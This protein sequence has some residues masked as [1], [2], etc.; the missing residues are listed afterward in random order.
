MGYGLGVDLG[1]SFTGVAISCHG[2]TRIVPLGDDPISGS[3]LVTVRPPGSLLVREIDNT[4]PVVLG[5]RPY[6]PVAVLAEVL[7]SVLASV[8]MSEGEVPEQVVLTCP[9]V[10][11]PAR[12][13]QFGEVSRRV[14]LTSVTVVSEPEAAVTSLVDGRKL[15]EDDVVVVYD[16]GGVTVDM[17][18]VRVTDSGT[19][20]LGLPEGADGAGGADFD[21]LLLAHVDRVLGG[22]LSELDLSDPVAVG[23]LTGVRAEC[24]RAK[25][26]L[27]RTGKVSVR[28][29]G[30]AEM[31]GRIEEVQPIRLTRT[32]FEA[33]IREPLTSTLAGLSR[34]LDSAGV[35]ASELRAVVLVGGSSRIPLVSRLLND[36]VGRPVLTDEHPQYCVALGAAAIADGT[37]TIADGV[38]KITPGAPPIT[39]SIPSF[40]AATKM[41]AAVK[42]V[43]N[44][45]ATKAAE[46]TSSGNKQSSGS[47]QRPQGK[48][49]FGSMQA[50]A[51]KQGKNKS[52]GKPASESDEAAVN[53]VVA[54]FVAP[55]GTTPVPLVS[56]RPLPAPVSTSRSEAMLA[57]PGG[58]PFPGGSA[59]SGGSAFPGGIALPGDLPLSAASG[60]T[61]DVTAQPLPRRDG[62]HRM[63]RM[64]ERRWWAGG[65]WRTVPGRRWRVIAA[66][67]V[68]AL[69]IGGTYVFTTVGTDPDPTNSV[70]GPADGTTSTPTVVPSSPQTEP[71]SVPAP[72]EAAAKTTPPQ[73]ETRKPTQSAPFRSAPDTVTASRSGRIVGLAGRCLDVADGRAKNGTAVQIFECNSSPA[74]KW[75]VYK[76]G[77][78]RA[79]NKCLQAV[80]VGA[81][82]PRLQINTCNGRAS[83]QW[84][85][86]SGVIVNPASAGCLDVQGSN[87]TART[88]VITANCGPRP[89]QTWWLQ[90]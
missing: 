51:V 8:T 61:V 48:S 72:T 24:V 84:V 31:I 40:A 60:P 1:T 7:R 88:P 14:G 32:E 11:G 52:T 33:L 36:S 64:R 50:F 57:F 85:V 76:D 78:L 56:P 79:M 70:A 46:D 82:R 44:K 20:I 27:S 53:A 23:V 21:D 26:A 74:Q 30:L 58:S 86:S 29:I 10:W 63:P 19:E 38:R 15:V 77:T 80:D 67:A 75:S 42:S 9:A 87:T 71:T 89:G 17:T 65:G 12:R 62:G 69:L 22:A 35:Q 25:E 41:A 13:Q 37:S 18:V 83:Q 81:G 2:R 54:P 59:F 39:D 5:G 34:V 4:V 28:V 49:A 43:E 6:P 45:T 73:Q 66:T 3:S 90:G 47:K 55:F 68:T 16:I